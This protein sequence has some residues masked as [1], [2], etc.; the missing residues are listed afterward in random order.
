MIVLFELSQMLSF[1]LLL[2]SISFLWGD[3][4]TR[5]QVC[6]FKVGMQSVQGKTLSVL[7]TEK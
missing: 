3:D 1:Y 7:R 4:I 2:L 6:W 5:V